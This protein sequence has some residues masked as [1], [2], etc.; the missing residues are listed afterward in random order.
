MKIVLKLMTK[1]LIGGLT[2]RHMGVKLI[3]AVYMV[4]HPSGKY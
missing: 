3:P 2:G 4:S 1:A